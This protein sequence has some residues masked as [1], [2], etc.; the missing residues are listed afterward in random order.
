MLDK[1]ET[2][3]IANMQSMYEEEYYQKYHENQRNYNDDY[4]NRRRGFFDDLFTF[5]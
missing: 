3:K 1:G 2:D 4:Y 5:D